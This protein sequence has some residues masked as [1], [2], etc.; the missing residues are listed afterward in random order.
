MA[1]RETRALPTS[2]NPGCSSSLLR[3]EF[4]T[5]GRDAELLRLLPVLG[6]FRKSGHGPTARHRRER[7]RE[8][9]CPAIARGREKVDSEQRA[10]A[11]NLGPER[12]GG[13]M[14]LSPARQSVV[15]TKGLASSFC[16]IP[17]FSLCR[18]A[19]SAVVCCCCERSTVHRRP[20]RTYVVFTT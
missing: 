12:L 10:L 19:R 11:S 15:Q 18:S 3:L 8:L 14:P 1:V 9:P 4:P 2:S 6:T 5:E 13:R 16:K 20:V 17:S 7:D